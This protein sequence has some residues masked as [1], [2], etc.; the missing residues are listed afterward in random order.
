MHIHITF[1]AASEKINVFEETLIFDIIGLIGSLGG[2]LGLFVG[3]SCFGYLSP[4]L[5]ALFDR[6]ADLFQQNM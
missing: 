3:F 1:L 5:D 2:S 4:V 6:P